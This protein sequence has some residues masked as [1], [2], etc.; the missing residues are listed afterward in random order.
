RIAFA[1]GQG[2]H[3]VT[4]HADD[5]APAAK[6]AVGLLLREEEVESLPDGRGVLPL[7]VGVPS[8][9]VGQQGQAGQRRISL[10]VGA[11][12]E[13]SLPRTTVHGEIIVALDGGAV[14]IAGDPSVPAPIFPILMACQ[15][16]EC[17]L[18][19]QLTGGAGTVALRPIRT[20]RIQPRLVDPRDLG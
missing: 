8:T 20:I 11:L 9:E 12:T 16:V 15:P 7:S 6:I 19:G 5:S 10:P 17:A 4:V 3:G 1:Q 14:V 18:H 2:C 13:A